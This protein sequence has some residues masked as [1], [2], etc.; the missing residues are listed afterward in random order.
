MW[1]ETSLSVA[2]KTQDSHGIKDPIPAEVESVEPGS[3]G[4]ELGFQPGDKLISINGIKP[5][6]LIDYRYLTVEEELDL[7]VMD[8]N[9]QV[10]QINFEKDNDEGLG[11]VFTEALFDGLKQGFL[12]SLNSCRPPDQNL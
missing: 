4:E 9:G 8:K 7:E 11:L 6:D 5:R 10:H 12:S 1:N 2:N 3:I